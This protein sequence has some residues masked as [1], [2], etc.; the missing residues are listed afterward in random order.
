MNTLEIVD[1]DLSDQNHAKAVLHITDHYAQDPMGIGKQLP[2]KTK[3]VL[4]EHLQ[5]FQHY[6]GFLAFVDSEPAGLANCFY[7]FS[8]FKAQK[9][10][11]IHDLAVLS[12]FRSKGI[13]EALLAAVERKAADENCSK[14][15]LEVRKDN[16]AKKLYE[17]FGFSNGE[18][19]ML[20]MEKELD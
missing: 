12:K 20:F 17:R 13:G 15:T 6:I 19:M 1:V 10:I 8:T 11:N 2:D 7:G 4:I 9:I 3:D 16:R 5:K 14:I 18:P